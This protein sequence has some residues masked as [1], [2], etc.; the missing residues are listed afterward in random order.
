MVWV[1]PNCWAKASF[2]SSRSTA[3]IGLA[4]TALAATTADKPTPP[5]PKITTL[6]PA[7]TPAVFSTAPAPVIT[8]Q[9]MMAVTSR[10]VSFAT[11]TT[12]CSSAMVVSAQV[13]TFCER[14][15]LPSGSVRVADSGARSVPL[16]FRGTQVT[17]T[18]SPA[19]TCSTALPTCN[20]IPVDSWPRTTGLARG[21][22]I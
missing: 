11:L 8:A 9:P 17:I 15:T 22:C 2:L 10:L 19:A 20:T 16:A 5:T 13:K 3:M 18:I 14:A 4:P 12:Y 7:L 6:S 1:A 21:L